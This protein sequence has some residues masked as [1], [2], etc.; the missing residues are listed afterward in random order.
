MIAQARYL[1]FSRGTRDV[2]GADPTY[3]CGPPFH[4]GSYGKPSWLVAIE[5]RLLR[6]R[7]TWRRFLSLL[8]LAASVVALVAAPASFAK[9]P[10]VSPCAKAEA[11]ESLGQLSAAQD[12][13]LGD[14]GRGAGAGCAQRGLARLRQL[15]QSCAYPDALKGVGERANAHAAYLK[16]LSSDSGSS[17]AVTGAKATAPVSPATTVWS[18][19]NSGA[20]NLGYVLAAVVL[21]LLAATILILGLLQIQTRTKLFRLRDR[22]PSKG[23]RRPSLDISGFDDTALGDNHFGSSVAGLVRGRVTWKTDRFGLNLVS[24]QAGIASALS[25]LG[26]VSG[27][28]KA[29]VAVINFLT[30]ILPRRRFVLK[31]VLQPAGAEGLGLSLELS[32]DGSAEALITLWGA[33]F[34]VKGEGPADDFQHLSVPAA[35]W[36]DIWMVK[37][38]QR[39]ELLT[40]DPQSWT[41]FRSGVDWQRLG[42]LSRARGLY[43]QALAKDGQNAGA[44]ANLGIIYQR[45]RDYEQADQYFNRALGPLQPLTPSPKLKSEDNPDWYR[46]KYQIAAL[47]ANWAALTP[48][49]PPR[50]L[51]LER[52]TREARALARTTLARLQDLPDRARRKSADEFLA[53]TLKPF[54]AGTISPSVLALVAS[55]AAPTL[56]PAPAGEL[57]SPPTAEGLLAALG[58]PPDSEGP[59][60][61]LDP[62]PFIAFIEGETSRA[63]A[64]FFNLACFYTR[65]WDLT[66][67]AQRLQTAVRETSPRERQALIDVAA[68]D[69]VLAPLQ[70]KRTGMIATLKT[71]LDPT[72]DL[73]EAE[74]EAL[75]EFEMEDRTFAW[76]QAEARSVQWDAMASGFTFKATNDGLARGVTVVGAAPLDKQGVSAILG[77]LTRFRQKH[78]GEYAEIRAL[79][80]VAK[81][82][83]VDDVDLADAKEQGIDFYRDTGTEFV[84]LG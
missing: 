32:R 30:A 66:T 40:G 9:A 77:D 31:G 58:T 76:L 83:N 46:V 61:E 13:F 74:K 52:A 10:A 63:P 37:A 14:L 80:I 50:T 11:L 39:D 47:F 26:D 84:P 75:N 7:R 48:E 41:F 44:L 36:V 4:L 29:A 42:D 3:E 24:G 73:D 55:T 12:T 17:C 70:A 59:L 33:P 64:K 69:P 6:R 51:R 43:E 8:W 2:S 21:A 16:L 81:D 38:L 1:Q 60:P 72:P 79:V 78:D 67:A 19:L 68:E 62:W 23:I 34:L 28:T 56:P 22:W 15:E 49:G 53:D 35:A 54:L 27:E 57:P 71:I 45:R 82:R 18:W 20:T 5:P 65:I 25:G